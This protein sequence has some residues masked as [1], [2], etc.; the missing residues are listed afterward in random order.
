LS[1]VPAGSGDIK[2]YTDAC[3]LTDH[4][5]DQ[6]VQDS[7]Y[8][9]NRRGVAG[10]LLDATITGDT[11]GYLAE[12]SNFWAD[13][14]SFDGITG[15]GCGTLAARPPT[16]VGGTGY[17]ATDQSCSNLTGLLGANPTTPISGTLYKCTAP[18]TWTSYYAPYT[19][20]HPLRIGADTTPPAAPSGLM[21]N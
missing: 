5:S 4:Y 20:P 17:W 1:G 15:I 18:N 8:W 3:P 16:C 19:Y 12:N 11:C 2:V 13:D 21:V 9:I 6:L 14:I 10:P 7:Y